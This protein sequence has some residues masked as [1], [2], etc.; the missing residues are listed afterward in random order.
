MGC[1]IAKVSGVLNTIFAVM[2][3]GMNNN[4]CRLTDSISEGIAAPVDC[5]AFISTK[6]IRSIGPE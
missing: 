1:A 6:S 5:M 4:P 2:R 3:I